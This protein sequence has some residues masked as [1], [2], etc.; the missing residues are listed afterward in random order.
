MGGGG[1]GG[2]TQTTKTTQQLPKWLQPYAQGL[3]GQAAG[4]YGAGQQYPQQSVAP[5][6][7]AQQQGFQDVQNVYNQ[8]GG[9]NQQLGGMMGQFG[10]LQGQYGGQQGQLGDLQSQL[11]GL[12]GQLSG[13]GQYAGDLAGSGVYPGL[14]AAQQANQ[15]FMSGQY[16]SP[17]SNPYLQDYYN[18]AAAPVIANYQNAVAPNL[19][20]NA[21]GAGGL[22]SSGTAS[23]FDAAQANLGTSLQ[24]L[25]SNMYEPAYQQG[26]QQMQT[27][28]GEQPSLATAMYTPLNEQLNIAGQQLGANQQ[29]AGLVGQQTGL[30]Q[31]E[32][33]LLGQQLGAN[34]QQMA[35]NQLLGQGA[36]N[37]IGIGGQQQQQLQN[38]LNTAFG[39]QM[40]P[41]NMLGQAAGLIGPLSGGGGTQVTVGPNPQQ[42]AK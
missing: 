35:A 41:Y 27:A 23:A 18:A 7:P 31:Q 34:Q 2:S 42:S 17:S 14:Q 8:L 38:I 26:M 19:L 5:F 33:N 25:A 6:S 21:I 36:Q 11:G 20:A 15:A 13:Y 10:G 30:T 16:A 37:I 1:G 32:Q 12:Q 24:D 40:T 22:G 39:N 9:L 28:I 29:Q 4:L 3:A